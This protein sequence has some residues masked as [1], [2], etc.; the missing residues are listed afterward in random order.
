MTGVAVIGVKH[1]QEEYA[2]EKNLVNSDKS[3]FQ[4]EPFYA[5]TVD[6]ALI[7]YRIPVKFTPTVP[8]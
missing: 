7:P 5:L 4:L 8:G 2:V 1:P 6:F 3:G